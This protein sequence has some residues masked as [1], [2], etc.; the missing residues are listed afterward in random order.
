MRNVLEVKAGL[1][2]NA[3]VTPGNK[4][5][6]RACNL[7]RF[8]ELARYDETICTEFLRKVEEKMESIAK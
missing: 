3:L 8:V 5:T 4:T 6:Y 7:G 1:F 2:T